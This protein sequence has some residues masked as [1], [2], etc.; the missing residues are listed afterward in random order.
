MQK[1]LRNQIPLHLSEL[2]SLAED[3]LRLN[4]PRSPEV[5][6][7]PQEMFRIVHELEVHQIELEIQQDELARSKIELEESLS[8]YTE[9]YDFAPCGYL[10]LAHDS[11]ILTANLTAT[12]ILAVDRTR[13]QGMYFKQFVVPEDYR[14]I[15]A[16]LD[17]VF[18]KSVSANCEVNL[19]SETAQPSKTHPAPAGRTVRIDAA[20]SDT[21]HTCRIILSDITERK[22]VENALNDSKTRF[23]QALDAA[24]AGVWEWDLET[25]EN[26]WSDELW[27][28]YGI[29]RTSEK[30]SFT[31]WA[32]SIHPD[33]R[34]QVI[35]AVTTTAANAKDLNLEYRVRYPDGTNHWIMSRGRPLYNDKGEVGRYIGTVIDIT[36]R[37]QAEE[38]LKKNEERFKALFDN[39]SSIM[40][41]I[42]PVTRKILDANNAAAEF[43]GWSIEELKMMQAEQISMTSLENLQADIQKI[44][45][46]ELS[47]CKR[48]HRRADGS[49]CDVE[50]SI[51]MIVIEGKELFYAVI[52]D[53]T[54]RNLVEKQLTKMSAAVQQSPAAVMITDSVGNIEFINPMFTKL[55]GYSAEEV[56]GK[57]PSIL[58]SGLISRE[59]Y[60]DLWTTI[61]SGGI[62]RGELQNRKKNGELYWES[63]VI[64][65]LLNPEGV[66]TNFVSV[67]EDITE[68]KM[69]EQSIAAGRAKLEAAL[70]SM[71]DALFISDSE[72]RFTDFND[73]FATFHRFSSKDE[74]A[75]TLAE[76]QDILD[77]FMPDGEPAPLE[78]WA[79]PRALRGEIATNAEYLL[80]RKDTGETWV[81]SYGLA[82]IRNKESEIVGSVV[83]ARDVT[84]QKQA[85]EALR[86]SEKRFRE[87]FEKHSAI[88]LVIEPE[89]GNII[90]AN[91]AAAD[92]YGWSVEELRKMS[93]LQINTLPPNEVKLVLEKWKSEDKLSFQFT[94]RRADGS[95]RDIE[96]FGCK[97]T[98]QG[99]AFVYLIIHDITD[100]KLAAE[101]SDRLKAAFIANI[102][103]EI[104]TPMNGILGFAELL[105]EPQLS[106]EEQTQ[107]IDLIHQSGQRMLN[108]VNDLMDISKI[109]AKEVKLEITETPVNQILRELK[110]FF[111]LEANKKRLRLTSTAG[112]SDQESIILTD[113]VKLNQIVTNLIQNALKFTTKGGIDFGYSKKDD[114]LEFYCIDSGIGVPLDK[115]EKIFERFHQANNSLTRNHEGA[116]L[117]LSI[118]KAFV[119]LMG[120]KIQVETSEGA[121]SNFTFTLPYI[122]ATA[123]VQQEV[124][125]SQ[126]VVDKQSELCML[127]AEDDD[128]STLLLKKN[129]KNDNVT[130]ITA[131]NGWEAVN[132]V[133]HHPEIN[134]VLMDIKM[135]VMNGFE[136]TR[137]IKE[138]RPDLPVIAQS[139]FTT[140]EDKEKAK[141]AGCD[142]FI[143]KPIKK[144]ELI[145]MIRELLWT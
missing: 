4:H 46:S 136:A 44:K 70:A 7:S 87:M 61:R 55:I 41:V 62:W 51:N 50:L 141:Q 132:L 72:G 145:E 30:A 27:P 83:S 97:I 78:Q 123:K 128:V 96:A 142:N 135:P 45:N 89:T 139:A 118:T 26:F 112:L 113:S 134:L 126:L 100:R 91:Q 22:R 117:G 104:R 120:G 38:A 74:C 85:E 84:A 90:N 76:Y 3:R 121:G 144:S 82:P 24:H 94:H 114:M 101:E 105:K 6:C 60:E 125:T 47:R 23:S 11:K 18:T 133:Q 95:I 79:V 67:K 103:H 9:L 17:K 116:G 10:T 8:Q 32:D 98:I 59:I 28:L 71:S 119:E 53:I 88:K 81:G 115:K 107:Y 137:L 37:K 140:N 130:I 52:N 16:L 29:K 143:T 99:K 19:L 129:F 39:H 69:A 34:E 75:T 93:I 127:I 13:L 48:K 138:H 36:D 66:I 1:K 73:A 58:K 2:R 40:L 14:V 31:L 92:F 108:L 63:E 64:S 57:N 33:D 65:P 20:I 43:Y 5:S 109:D 12:K 124:T 49:S 102:S 35:N 80:R 15:D 111:T 122:P 86:N 68:Q 56:I 110:A 77:V 25:N 131:E 42:D 21:S 106:G 54:E